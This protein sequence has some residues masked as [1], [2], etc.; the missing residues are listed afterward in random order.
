M[1]IHNQKYKDLTAL[2]QLRKDY[3]QG[4]MS[5]FI[6]AGFSLNVSDLYLTWN[7]LLYDM[8]FKTG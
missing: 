1:N 5:A 8:V 7:G 2:E 4:I 3:E 6:G